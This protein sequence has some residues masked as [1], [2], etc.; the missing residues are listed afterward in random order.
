M[1]PDRANAAKVLRATSITKAALD[2][3]EAARRYLALYQEAAANPAAVRTL[4][5]RV[6]AWRTV[7][8]MAE[9]TATLAAVETAQFPPAFQP[10]VPVPA[11]PPFP[12]AVGVPAPA[13][14]PGPVDPA[15]F[16]SSMVVVDVVLIGMEEDRRESRGV[17]LLNGLQLQ[18][19]DPIAGTPGL[20]FI[21]NKARDFVDETQSVNTRT[22]T[23]SIR[24]P[25]V[26][27]SLNI[28]NS[29][30]SQNEILAKPSLV[31]LAGQTSEFFSGVDVSAAAVSGGQG[32]SVSIQKEVGVKLRVTPEF[33]PNDMIRL[34]IV[35]ERTFLTDPSTSVLFQFRLDTTKTILNATVAMKFGETLI[36]GGLSEREN[37]GSS[38][39]VPILKDI[40]ITNYFFSRD[41]ARNFERSILILL[42]PRRPAYGARAIEDRKQDDQKLSEFE[43]LL[44]KFEK[45]HGKWFIPRRTFDAIIERLDQGDFSDEF[46][47][48]DIPPESWHRRDDMKSKVGEIIDRVFSG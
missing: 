22:V 29:L 43:R 42:T 37:S 32:D 14:A 39:G 34:Q 16:D 18:F 8:D 38:D 15:F 10:P 46:R 31:A 11:P 36:L 12:G 40:P 7:Y 5:R 19:G 41:V 26:T 9:P 17:N 24:I 21:K 4:T 44:D 25:S 20:S 23:R 27:Y 35:A 30:S 1:A 48:G 28:A 13:G 33:L 3:R 45:R 47:T 2:Q 6:G